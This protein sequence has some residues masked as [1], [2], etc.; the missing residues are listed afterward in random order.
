MQKYVEKIDF[1]RDVYTNWFSTFASNFP[2]FIIP[3]LFKL[4]KMKYLNKNQKHLG[5]RCASYYFL[6][7]MLSKRFYKIIQ[8]KI[9]FLYKP[10]TVAE[11]SY[12][13]KVLI[14]R[15]KFFIKKKQTKTPKRQ[16]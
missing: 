10:S 4:E 9:S 6:K 8:T 16:S 14:I 1:F 7:T 15:Q 12:G 3:L 11:N 13:N 2:S 5:N